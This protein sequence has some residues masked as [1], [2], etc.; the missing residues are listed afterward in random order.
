MTPLE[1]N[2]LSIRHDVVFAEFR[3]F[4]MSSFKFQDGKQKIAN[5]LCNSTFYGILMNTSVNSIGIL[6]VKSYCI[7]TKI[8]VKT[9]THFAIV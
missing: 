4:G 6:V 7:F 1:P 2:P 9:G 8:F 5:R 3:E